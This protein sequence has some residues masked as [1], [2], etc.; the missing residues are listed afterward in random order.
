MSSQAAKKSRRSLGK[1]SLTQPAGE[2]LNTSASTS[3]HQHHAH[4]QPAGLAEYRERKKA[5][6]LDRIERGKKLAE[7]LKKGVIRTHKPQ[8]KP[9]KAGLGN[10]N[11][12]LAI[13]ISVLKNSFFF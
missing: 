12:S 8:T 9:Q 5:E 6:K 1:T 2:S 10:C 3:S 11:H 7:K 13:I 4:L